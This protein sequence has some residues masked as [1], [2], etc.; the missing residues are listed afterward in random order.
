MRH[1]KHDRI[2]HPYW[3]AVSKNLNHFIYLAKISPEALG[4]SAADL[5]SEYPGAARKD[6]SVQTAASSA[7]ASAGPLIMNEGFSVRY[8]MGRSFGLEPDGMI[9]ELLPQRCVYT[10]CKARPVIS[11]EQL[12]PVLEWIRSRN[13]KV[14]GDIL[15]RARGLSYE[16][17]EVCRYY[18]INVPVED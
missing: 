5:S 9:E 16:D 15:C 2:K 13:F 17:G 3:D 6:T 7:C 11:A 4:C 12:N 14:A 10:V 1:T 18:D 8:E